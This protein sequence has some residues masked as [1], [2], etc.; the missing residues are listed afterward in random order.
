M[1]IF[2]SVFFSTVGIC[3]SCDYIVFDVRDYAKCKKHG[4]IYNGL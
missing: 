3:K 4:E 1:V 2:G